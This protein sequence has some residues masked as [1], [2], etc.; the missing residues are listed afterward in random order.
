MKQ[1]YRGSRMVLKTMRCRWLGKADL[2]RWADLRNHDPD[3]D[4][5]T[6]K[7][8]EI[9]PHGAR[10]VEFGAGRRQLEGYLDPACTYFPSDIVERDPGTIV[11]DLNAR[12]LPDLSRLNLDVAVFGGTLEYITDLRSLASWLAQSVSACIASYECASS[13]PRTVARTL[14]S[15]RRASIG[16]VNTYTR[17][18]LIGIFKSEG[19]SYSEEHEFTERESRGQI[20]VLRK[21]GAH[22]AVYIPAKRS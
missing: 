18:E 19:F 14:E 9:V 2:E 22:E 5:R 3:W 21:F 20:F 8:A 15:F 11:F 16:W 4:D 13:S 10:V 7:L 6:R 12:P 17:E 1:V